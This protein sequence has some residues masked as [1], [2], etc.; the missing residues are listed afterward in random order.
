MFTQF[1]L[2]TMQ[3][4]YVP[5]GGNE[6]GGGGATPTS[7]SISDSYAKETLIFKLGNDIFTG[8]KMPTLYTTISTL[9]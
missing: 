9:R 6:G 2:L 4:V 7:I 5:E 1:G 8:F 3:N